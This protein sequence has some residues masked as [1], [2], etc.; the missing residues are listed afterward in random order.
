MSTEVME[1]V[2][3]R[4]MSDRAFAELLFTDIHKAISGYDLTSEE[5]TKLRA[6][7]H[8]GFDQWVKGMKEDRDRRDK[9]YDPF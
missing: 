5:I 7:F 9:G 2:L 3:S 6:I 4:A 1:S 8:D